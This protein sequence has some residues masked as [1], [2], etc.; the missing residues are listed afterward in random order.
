MSRRRTR[1]GAVERNVVSADIGE[2]F[3]TQVLNLLGQELDTLLPH[4]S[5]KQRAEVFSRVLAGEP[6]HVISQATQ[7]PLSSTK[8][9][10][11]ELLRILESQMR[12]G[13]LGGQ[14]WA[15]LDSD[16]VAMFIRQLQTAA[17]GYTKESQPACPYHQDAAPEALS[18]LL[19]KQCEACPCALP[20]VFGPIQWSSLG[21]P[22]RYCSNGCRQRAYRRRQTEREHVCGEQIP[23]FT[24]KSLRGT[25]AA[26][27]ELS[28]HLSQG[29]R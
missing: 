25:R 4:H 22:R 7:R 12:G 6:L 14:P 29:Y 26:K 23:L 19:N 27:T 24:L 3:Y 20:D 17:L 1:R 16:D 18:P 9:V 10:F 13:F 5:P 28:V 2:G 15:D 8:I 11:G 21:R